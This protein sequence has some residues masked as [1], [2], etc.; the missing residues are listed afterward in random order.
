VQQLE[1]D[2]DGLRHFQVGAAQ[3]LQRDAHDARGRTRDAGQSIDGPARK[4][5]RLV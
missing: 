2:A 3:G 5:Q 1:G 4:I